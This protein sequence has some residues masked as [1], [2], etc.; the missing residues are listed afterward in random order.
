MESETGGCGRETEV[1]RRLGLKR[2]IT[3]SRL[4]SF[5][6][7]GRNS[8]DGGLVFQGSDS[9]AA[10]PKLSGRKGKECAAEKEGVA[11]GERYSCEVIA[12]ET[13]SSSL[14]H[15]VKGKYP[16]EQQWDINFMKMNGTIWLQK[17]ETR[18]RKRDCTGA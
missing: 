18:R 12:V 16:I 10:P 2:A 15:M 13:R 4:S 3:V 17:K 9:D 14:V 1:S 5:G 6:I 7:S 8:L 11:V